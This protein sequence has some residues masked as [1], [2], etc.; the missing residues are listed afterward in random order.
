MSMKL[1][2]ELVFSLLL[3]A[4]V[5]SNAGEDQ[6]P[7]MWCDVPDVSVT[8]VGDTYWMTST[9]NHLCPHVPVMKSKDLVNWKIVSYCSPVLE[10]GAHERLDMGMNEYSR[11]TWASSIRYH[12]GRFVVSTFNVH[13]RVT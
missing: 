2:K 9:S 10:N 4:A 12:G 1:I 11:G 3:S 7:V 8:R 5:A 13:T 6:N